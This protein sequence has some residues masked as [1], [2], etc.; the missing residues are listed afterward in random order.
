MCFGQTTAWAAF[1]VDKFGLAILP[2]FPLDFS[3]LTDTIETDPLR[4]LL[5]VEHTV[6]V[7]LLRLG[8]YAIAVY[9]GETADGLQN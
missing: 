1:R 2:G 9:R 6:G 7:A 4:A 3:G 5:T 8:R